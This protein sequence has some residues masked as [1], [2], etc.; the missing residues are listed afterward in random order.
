M[1]GGVACNGCVSYHVEKLTWYNADEGG[2]LLD[3]LIGADHQTI[4][5]AMLVE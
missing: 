1:A 2:K 3:L 4:H 5:G